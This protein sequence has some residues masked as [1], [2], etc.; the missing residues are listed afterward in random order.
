MNVDSVKTLGFVKSQKK[1]KEALPDTFEINPFFTHFYIGNSYVERKMKNRQW[2]VSRNIIPPTDFF[3]FF[4]HLLDR[5]LRFISTAID[6]GA[7]HCYS[8]YAEIPT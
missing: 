3:F 2:R 4:P 5:M 7:V 1:V 8:N 6:N